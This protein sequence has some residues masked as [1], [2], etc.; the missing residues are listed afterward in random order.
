M[1]ERYLYK[2][3][4]DVEIATISGGCKRTIFV[5]VTASQL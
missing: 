3:R 5:V 1:E 2:S 4:D